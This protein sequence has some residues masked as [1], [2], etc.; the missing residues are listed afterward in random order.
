MTCKQS[1][2]NMKAA[3]AIYQEIS[4]DVKIL[5][6]NLS[7]SNKIMQREQRK[8]KSNLGRK[9]ADSKQFSFSKLPYLWWICRAGLFLDMDPVCS[10]L[11][12]LPPPPHTH[13]ICGL[14][15]YGGKVAVFYEFWVLISSLS[16]W[17]AKYSFLV[18]KMWLLITCHSTI[19]LLFELVNSIL[20]LLFFHRTICL[21][22]SKKEGGRDL[23]ISSTLIPFINTKQ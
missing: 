7:L 1:A 16:K 5:Q 19:S 15:L 6:S 11:P 14:Y 2:R 22:H 3:I 20:L 21:R 12:V 10:T 17:P 4:L 13:L 9:W 18:N 23:H 8:K